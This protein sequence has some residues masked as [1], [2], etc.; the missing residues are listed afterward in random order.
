LPGWV[1]IP[2]VLIVSV[3][4]WWA[5][6][7]LIVGCS[8]APKPPEQPLRARSEPTIEEALGPTPVQDAIAMALARIDPNGDVVFPAA[9]RRL[10]G[11]SACISGIPLPYLIPQVQPPR[12]GVEWRCLLVTTACPTPPEPDWPMWLILSTRPPDPSLPAELSPLGL[13]GCWL[14]VNLDMLVSIPP[15]PIE[16]PMLLREPGRGAA[17]LRWTP[18]HSMVGQRLWMQL[19]VAAPRRSP[20]G[21]LTSY[22]LELTVG[23]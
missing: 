9:V 7:A 20:G 5:A 8:A 4:G 10:H 1:A 15:G 22:A 14:H 12:A 16:S 21:F 19:M 6:V 23:S 18:G 17:T 3:L 2:A 13:R 11:K